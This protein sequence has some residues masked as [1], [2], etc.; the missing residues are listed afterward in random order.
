MIS[1]Y[2][3]YISDGKRYFAHTKPIVDGIE[4]SDKKALF[5]HLQNSSKRFF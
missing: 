2:K 3:F 5:D 1:F 4:F